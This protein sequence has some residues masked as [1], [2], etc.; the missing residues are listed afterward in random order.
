[1]SKNE[2]AY[3]IKLVED[4]RRKLINDLNKG[5]YSK[6]IIYIYLNKYDNLLLKLYS[7]YGE[8]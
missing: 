7:K 6:K 1:M 5:I 2:Y 3:L 4:N 8:F